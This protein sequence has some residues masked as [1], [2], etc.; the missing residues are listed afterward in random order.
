VSALSDATPQTEYIQFDTEADFQAAVDRLLAAQ[1][2]ELRVFDPDLAALRLNTP[3]RVEQLRQ[4]LAASRTRRL[5]IAVHNPD[6]LTRYCPRM[7]ALL[8]RFAHAIQI[9]CTHEEIRNL[10]DSFLVID[11]SHY[12]RR[13]VAQQFR[14]ALG[15]HD[16]TEALMMRTRYTEIWSASFPGVS[17]STLGL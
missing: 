11:Q 6:H 8:A 3:Q 9:N 1:G 5:Y 17:A 10:Q 2:R 16:E 13:P 4:F 7:M 12:L 14:G 15:L